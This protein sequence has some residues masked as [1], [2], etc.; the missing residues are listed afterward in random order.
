MPDTEKVLTFS[1]TTAN[2]AIVENLVDELCET[3]SI[4]ED[5]YGNILI[6][7]TEAVNNAIVHGNKLDEDKQV[8]V[9]VSHSGEVLKFTIQDE[10]PG[11]DYD[12]LPDPTAPENIEKPNGRGV[13]LMKNLA[14][15]CEFLEDG[16][17]VALEFDALSA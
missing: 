5:F 1:S 16:T 17:I 8:R 11:F 3:H 14:D 15:R 2:I 13:F 12:N 6:A 7:L 9:A 4:K 10:G